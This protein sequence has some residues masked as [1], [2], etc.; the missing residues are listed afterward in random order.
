MPH[1]KNPLEFYETPAAFTRWLFQT[2]DIRGRI[3]EP[4]AGAGAIERDSARQW[5]EGSPIA[6]RSDR[7]WVL[8]DID[9]F[10]R[11]NQ[12][13]MDATTQRYWDQVGELHWT[14]SNPPFEPALDIIEHALAHSQV[15]VAMHLRASIHEPLKTGPR[16]TWFREHRPT[17]ILWLPRFAY[18]RSPSTGD[19][20]TDSVCACW[21]IWLQDQAAVPFIDYA[22]EWVMDELKTDT[23]AYRA[24]MDAIAA[25]RKAAA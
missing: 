9:P 2:V 16:R 24:R 11:S 8:N 15:G 17:G 20:T 1:E 23:P 3:A 19:W 7:E 14:V 4:C 12:S 5:P 18:Q 10:W 6:F 13:H 21:V 22:P 25:E